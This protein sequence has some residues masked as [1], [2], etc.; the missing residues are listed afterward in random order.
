[1][2]EQFDPTRKQENVPQGYAFSMTQEAEQQAEAIHISNEDR[3]EQGALLAYKGG[4]VTNLDERAWKIARTETFREQFG[5]WQQYLGLEKK[6]LSKVLQEIEST[7]TDKKQKVLAKL[8]LKQ[9]Q[10]LDISLFEGENP[11][12]HLGTAQTNIA[13]ENGVLK[14]TNDFIISE[15]NLYTTKEGYNETVLHESLHYFTNYVI[16]LLEDENN[17]EHDYLL[18]DT[19]KDFYKNL[20]NQFDF[21]MQNTERP[22]QERWLN[23]YEFLTYV[24]TEKAHQEQADGISCDFPGS[25]TSEYGN[26][27]NTLLNAVYNNFK[28]FISE[29]GNFNTRIQDGFKKVAPYLDANGEPRVTLFERPKL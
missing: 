20:K 3:N 4:P 29:N 5:E 14:S 7:T 2:I 8:L 1:M 6:K 23:T 26:K 16:L 18:N 21:F 27:T 28:N 15:P 12:K 17:K 25:E 24:M 22:E 11:H 10:N 13:L 9:A 19:E